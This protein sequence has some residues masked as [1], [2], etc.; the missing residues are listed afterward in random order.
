MKLVIFV[1]GTLSILGGVIIDKMGSL[2]EIVY[3]LCGIS[4]GSTVGVFTMGMLCPWANRHVSISTSR[5]SNGFRIANNMFCS[6]E[7]SMVSWSVWLQFFASS[8]T[9]K[10]LLEMVNCIT[11]RC[12]HQLKDALP[13]RSTRQVEHR[14]GMKRREPSHESNDWCQ[15]WNWTL[16]V[17][18]ILYE[19]FAFYKISFMWYGPIGLVLTWTIG[20]VTSV[21]TGGNDLNQFNMNLLSPYVKRLLP[22]KYRHI[23]LQ[24]VPG[25]GMKKMKTQ[26]PHEKALIPTGE[27]ELN[28]IGGKSRRHEPKTWNA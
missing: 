20:I 16:F 11:K 15:L 12:Q 25:N 9:H 8:S 19:E 24:P 3:T 22:K 10:W 14:L 6:R 4:S 2:F 13:V 23:Q 7:H 27:W 17:S 28:S 1:L 26:G 21:L 18:S 5:F